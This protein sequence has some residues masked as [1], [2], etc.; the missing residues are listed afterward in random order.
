MKRHERSQMRKWEVGWKIF[1]ERNSFFLH[2]RSRKYP[3]LHWTPIFWI[4]HKETYSNFIRSCSLSF[5]K[6][7]YNLSKREIL[8]CAQSLSVW[9]PSATCLCPS[10][11]LEADWFK[12]TSRI[13][14]KIHIFFLFDCSSLHWKF[15][16][17]N[18]S[19]KRITEKC[20]KIFWITSSY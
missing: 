9:P 20:L 10:G 2:L 15:T 12:V 13:E 5:D 6:E 1:C 7:K 18:V 3:I 17:F 4:A 19:K 14:I 16:L 8:F 11:C